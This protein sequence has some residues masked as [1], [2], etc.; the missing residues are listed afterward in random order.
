MKRFI[1]RT[2]LFI[3]LVAVTIE[4]TSIF[5]I[6]TDLFLIYIPGSEIYISIEKS[7]I[8]NDSKK[9]L[10]GDS[11]G[12]QMYSNKEFSYPVNSLACNQA[13][14]MVGQYVLLKSYLDSG[15]NPDEVYMI[16]TPF[17]FQNNLDQ[18]YTFHYFLKPFYKAEFKDDFS[19]LVFQ[20]I[21]KIPYYQFSRVPHIVATSWAPDYKIDDSRKDFFLSPISI[22]YLKKIK[23]LSMDR[24]FHFELVPPPTNKNFEAIISAMDREAIEENNLQDIF[25]DY[26]NKIIYLDSTEFVDGTHLKDPKKYSMLYAEKYFN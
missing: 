17:S 1:L 18:K 15:N 8:E 2:I 14:G 9:V 19:D 5:L 11:V 25:E 16:L 13:I 12:R 4:L 20:Q 21:Q 26:F 6:T 22:E 10:L 24:G 3:F 7:R 23:Q